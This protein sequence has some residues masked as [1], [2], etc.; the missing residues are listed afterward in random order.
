[1]LSPCMIHNELPACLLV[2]TLHHTPHLL[3]V[4]NVAP[5]IR[6][7]EDIQYPIC[8][9]PLSSRNRMMPHKPAMHKPDCMKRPYLSGREVASQTPI[10]GSLTLHGDNRRACC[11]EC[12]GTLDHLKG[13]VQMM[14]YG[15]VAYLHDWIGNG[16]ADVGVL[17]C[18]D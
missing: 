8:S 6:T 1:M 9:L 14:Q 17:R 5:A 18:Q 11:D 3:R 12:E 16:Q 4:S 10:M 15:H 2:G 7:T 13:A